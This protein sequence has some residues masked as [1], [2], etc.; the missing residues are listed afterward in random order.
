MSKRKVMI[1]LDD[2]KLSQ[3]IMPAVEKLF[4]PDETELLL[5]SV[6][7]PRLAPELRG[8]SSA[9]SA[10][11]VMTAV[12][13]HGEHTY[14]H[15]ME[16]QA[17]RYREIGEALAA[18]R[19]RDLRRVGRTLEQAGY[20]VRTDAWT[21]EAAETICTYAQN[22]KVDVIAMATHGRSGLSRMLMGS[23]AEEVVRTSPIPVL[24]LRPEEE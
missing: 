17:A 15:D 11:D 16:E 21:G 9:P 8:P 1:P 18:Q 14:Q 3:Q 13:L 20:S 7:T 19:A 23:V 6:V 24:L 22:K 4:S 12:M 2:S 5:F 10:G